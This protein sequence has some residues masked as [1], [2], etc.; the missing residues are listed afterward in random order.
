MK[1]DNN[2]K[3]AAVAMN[4]SIAAML[5]RGAF[6]RSVG[7]AVAG[8]A[9]FGGLARPVRAEKTTA[10]AGVD[11][12]PSQGFAALQAAVTAGGVV[13][14]HDTWDL[15]NTELTIGLGNNDVEIVGVNA[16]IQN[17]SISSQALVKMKLNNLVLTTNNWYC[18]DIV[19]SAGATITGCGIRCLDQSQWPIGIAS[20]MWNGVTDVGQTDVRGTLL[21]ENNIIDGIYGVY[22]FETK[23]NV[24]ISH[25]TIR[26]CNNGMSMVLPREGSLNID[27]NDLKMIWASAVGSLLQVSDD[28]FPSTFSS[29]LIANNQ[30]DCGSCLFAVGC[31]RWNTQATPSIVVTKNDV[32]MDE[33]DWGAFVLHKDCDDTVWANNRVTGKIKLGVCVA[34]FDCPC[35]PYP[36]THHAMNNVF[37]SNNFSGAVLD[38]ADNGIGL[39]YPDAADYLFDLNADYN[40]VIG[41]A[42]EVIDFGIGNTITG[43]KTLKQHHEPVGGSASQAEELIQALK[44]MYG[45]RHGPS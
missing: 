12:Y 30:F 2:V 9:G 39:I 34:T 25:N 43:S 19:Q 4:R 24:S 41:D 35:P 37:K 8:A 10:P 23:A 6:L 28:L 32:H 3:E 27:G 21:I 36:R 11:V 44:R 20:Y 45:R 7:A 40:T 1:L 5:S 17:C 16:L 13:Y 26:N 14:V 29:A 38:I 15:Q 18:V 42:G 31:G 22:L 33:N